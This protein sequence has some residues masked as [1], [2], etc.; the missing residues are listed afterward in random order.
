[1]APEVTLGAEMPVPPEDSMHSIS[2][3]GIVKKTS[4]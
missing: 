3:K 4:G 2:L 1:M